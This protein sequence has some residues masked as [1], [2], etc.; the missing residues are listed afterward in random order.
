[1]QHV[2][3]Y[4]RVSSKSQDHRSQEPDLIRH[5]E[6]QDSPVVWYKDKFSGR[7]MDR[8]GWNKLIAAM[9]E[10]KISKIVCWRL[11]RLGRTAKGLTELFEELIQRK[12]NLVSVKDGIDLQTSAGR[13]I[14]HVLA[15]VAQYENEVRT[16]RTLAG[17][18][19][20]RAA[21]KSWGGSQPG[22]RLKVTEEQL[23]TIQ[24]M[25]TDKKKIASIARATGLSRQTVYQYIPK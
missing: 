6:M 7:T 10:G 8:V 16:E 19:V 13:L 20:A 15:S 1:M 4:V 17:Q 18:A 25:F 23:D 5:S 22:R 14:A 9:R 2:A 11:D 24:K 21:G 3:Y 12:V